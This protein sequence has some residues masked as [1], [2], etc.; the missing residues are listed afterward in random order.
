ME[1]D[2]DKIKR[3]LLSGLITVYTLFFLGMSSEYIEFVHTKYGINTVI[4]FILVCHISLQVLFALII[5]V[6][7]ITLILEEDC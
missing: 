7:F 3:I 6:Y 4:D 1:I 5:A 2:F